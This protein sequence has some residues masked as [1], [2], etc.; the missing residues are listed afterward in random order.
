MHNDTLIIPSLRSL[1]DL[2]EGVV[3]DEEPLNNIGHGKFP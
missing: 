1:Q 3:I 2:L